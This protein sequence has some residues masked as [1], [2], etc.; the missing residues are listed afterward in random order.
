MMKNGKYT[1]KDYREE[2]ILL[3]LKRS[4]TN[5]KLTDK[6][7]NRIIKDIKNLESKIG[8]DE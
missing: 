2:M 6:E 5:V 3:G 8:M 7:K 1:C 4:L